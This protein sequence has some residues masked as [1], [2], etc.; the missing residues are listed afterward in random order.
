MEATLSEPLAAGRPRLHPATPLFDLMNA[1]ARSWPIV[2]AFVVGDRADVQALLLLLIAITTGAQVVKWFRTTYALSPS[3]LVVDSGLLQRNH[4]TVP[5]DRVQQVD[6]VRKLRH[7]L[8]GVASL[9]IETAA[10]T[11]D[12]SLTLDALS[13]AEAE[14]LRSVLD[15][16]RRRQQQ[17][18]DEPPP[19]A[20]KEE[21]IVRLPIGD[22]LL[23]G[24]TG[25]KLAAVLA[26][27]SVLSDLL[28]NDLADRFLPDLANAEAPTVGRLAAVALVLVSVVAWLGLAGLA[29][30]LTDHDFWLRRRGNQL[31][32]TRG[33]LERREVTVPAHRVQVVGVTQTILRRALRRCAVRA[34]TA[35]GKF[36]IPLARIDDVDRLVGELL[37]VGPVPALQLSPS[38]ARRRL[39]ARRLVPLSLIGGATA[40]AAW[41]GGLAAV[42]LLPLAVLW[43]WAAWR[44]LGHGANSEVIA[45]RAGVLYRNLEVVP[46]AKAQSTRV[47]SSPFQRRAGLASL[48]VDVAGGSAATVPEITVDRAREMAA[49]ATSP[50]AVAVDERAVRAR[51]SWLSHNGTSAAAGEVGANGT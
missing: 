8:F 38:A 35:A 19:A 12:A 42:V 39:I 48:F 5:Y 22:V 46:L 32:V 36:A 28:L 1:L 23:A 29:S 30:V 14:R 47:R 43:G 44:G 2:I 50:E 31:V 16:S 37:R 21:T 7:R 10:G 11:S 25:A 40:A 34:Q 24:V 26:A 49:A 51:P 3:A 41:P 13:L 27:G 6:V 15:P 33:L 17:Q 4:R 20:P 9:T 18:P 45:S